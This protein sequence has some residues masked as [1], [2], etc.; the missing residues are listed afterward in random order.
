MPAAPLATLARP[1]RRWRR[2]VTR[3]LLGSATLR[4]IAGLSLLVLLAGG[5]WWL[6]AL[7][8]DLGYDPRRL[9]VVVPVLAGAVT[10]AIHAVGADSPRCC[11]SLGI[12]ALA[13]AVTGGT[14]A[15]LLLAAP[16]LAHHST[17]TYAVAGFVVDSFAGRLALSIA[18]LLGALATVRLVNAAADR[19]RTRLG[20][21]TAACMSNRDPS[22][23]PP[24][25]GAS[26]DDDRPSA[27]AD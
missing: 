22:Q 8:G 5:Y 2:T 14:L 6:L 12:G 20:W 23:A 11:A 26:R 24:D 19:V 1:L 7:A 25:G 15:G 13:T 21:P 16:L 4:S 3:R 10:V 18:G 17:V 9:L 27:A